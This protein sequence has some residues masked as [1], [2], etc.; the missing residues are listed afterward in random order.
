MKKEDGNKEVVVVVGGRGE[1]PTKQPLLISQC[2][3]SDF[4]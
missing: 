3:I 2:H 1:G 4:K